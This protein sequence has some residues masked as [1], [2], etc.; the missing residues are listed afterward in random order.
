MTQ[1]VSTKSFAVAAQF[2]IFSVAM[3]PR[4]SYRTS[5]TQMFA[6]GLCSSGA[7]EHD[8]KK[9]GSHSAECDINDGKFGSYAKWFQRWW[10]VDKKTYKKN[11][12]LNN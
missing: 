4:R 8:E 1:L 6:G 10:K 2:S 3:T 11:G 12:M 9:N 7:N 5:A